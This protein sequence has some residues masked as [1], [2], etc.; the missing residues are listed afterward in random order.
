MSS[1]DEINLRFAVL[2]ELEKWSEVIR[3]ALASRLDFAETTRES[4]CKYYMSA[5][6]FSGGM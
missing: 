6:R 1:F 2:A 3:N 4:A 5:V